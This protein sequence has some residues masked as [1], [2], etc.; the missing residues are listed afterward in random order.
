MAIKLEKE[1]SV[2]DTMIIASRETGLKKNF[3]GQRK[4]SC[5][6]IKSTG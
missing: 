3:K 4:L 6:E 2:K 1:K 5:Q